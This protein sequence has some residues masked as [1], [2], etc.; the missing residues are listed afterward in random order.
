MVV[1]TAFYAL[2][3]VALPVAYLAR[4]AGIQPPSAIVYENNPRGRV[5][6]MTRDAMSGSFIM[7]KGEHLRCV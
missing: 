5:I 6:W 4:V 1:E 2:C 3:R 7:G